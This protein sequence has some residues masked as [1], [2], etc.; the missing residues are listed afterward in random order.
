MGTWLD[1]MARCAGILVT[2]TVVLHV[3]GYIAQF[4][5]VRYLVVRKRGALAGSISDS[6]D[7]GPHDSRGL[8]SKL[9]NFAEG[10][11]R[12]SLLVTG[13]IPSHCLRN[14]I[15]RN[16]FAMKIAHNAV[17]YG[18]AEIRSPFN[19]EIMEGA[20]IG[21]NSILDGRS[22][23]RIGRNANLSTGVW[24][25]TLQ[26]DPQCPEFSCRGGAARVVIGDRAWI[27]C[28]VV[29]LPG[30]TIGEGAVVAAG[31]V[32]TKDLEPFSINAGIPAKKI[33]SRNQDLR[34]EFDGAHLPFY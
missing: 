32:V 14:W 26:H 17:I 23:L 6:Q 13:R 10:W 30:V 1:W 24:I 18:G 8:A 19:I 2:A 34:Y 15:Y 22:G 3:L 9:K 16:V 27:S 7:Q 21:D 28:K 20:I 29:I 11:M 4:V 33:G 5:A 12:F 25:W 31:S